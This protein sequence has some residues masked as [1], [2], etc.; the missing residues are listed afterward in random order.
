[1]IRCIVY[2]YVYFMLLTFQVF[3][4]DDIAIEFSVELFSSS[5]SGI[6]ERYTA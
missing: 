5:F 1:M 3:F 6:A 2:V 4:V